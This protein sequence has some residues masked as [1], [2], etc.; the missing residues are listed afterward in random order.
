M[1]APGA[2][3]GQ[4]ACAGDMGTPGA[5][6]GQVSC[7]GDTGTPGTAG[8]RVACA[9]I[10]DGGEH[11]TVSWLNKL[12]VTWEVLAYIFQRNFHSSP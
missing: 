9:I 12:P 7:A 4:V 6:G 8:G 1:G 11:C 10:L 2:A 5:T 3:G